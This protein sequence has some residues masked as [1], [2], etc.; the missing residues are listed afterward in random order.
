M[1]IIIIIIIIIIINDNTFLRLQS[2]TITSLHISDLPCPTA[3][4]SKSVITKKQPNYS[5]TQCLA[6]CLDDRKGIKHTATCNERTAVQLQ[7]R[8][9]DDGISHVTPGKPTL[10]VDT[11]ISQN[12]CAQASHNG[13]RWQLQITVALNKPNRMGSEGLGTEILTCFMG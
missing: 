1:L 4:P 10:A 8:N 11:D 12:T 6:P 5:F 13:G 2:S 3:F 7:Q 9:I